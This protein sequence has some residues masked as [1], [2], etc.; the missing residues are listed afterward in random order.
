MSLAM[1][2]SFRLC[3]QLTKCSSVE[4]R[5]ENSLKTPVQYFL[6][7]Q[8]GGLATFCGAIVKAPPGVKKWDLKVIEL[9]NACRDGYIVATRS[10]IH[11]KIIL[12][13]EVMQTSCTD[14]NR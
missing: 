13:R 1:V 6:V 9:L 2:A 11:G 4:G 7:V 14:T 12:S 8:C 3:T 5:Q 10:R